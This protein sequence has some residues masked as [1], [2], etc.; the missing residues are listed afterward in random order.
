[1]SEENLTDVVREKIISKLIHA[2]YRPGH[3]FKLREMT[4]SDEFEGISQ[5]PIREALLQLVA[6][7]ILVGQR[8]FSIRVP[9]PTV[10]SL[11]EVR[12]IRIRLEIMAAAAG[13]GHWNKA[14][15][16]RL[17]AIHA[18]LMKAKQAEDTD[19]ILR[20]NVQFHF[21]LYEPSNMPYLMSMLRQLWAITGPS[22]RYLYETPNPVV[23]QG[24]HSHEDIIEALSARNL[25]Q[26]EEAIRAD[27][28]IHGQK[29]LDMLHRNLSLE[30]LAVQPFTKI[31]GTRKRAH[32]G[33]LIVQQS[34][35]AKPP[36]E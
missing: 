16:A 11:T 17:S 21:A 10:Q 19:D 14:R 25:P 3:A 9:T 24:R 35:E 34:Q 28:V 23:L 26:L 7:S 2:E 12:S 18:R 29:I 22:I 32:I 4:Q 13:I 27:G 5:T 36:G 1:M 6:Q 30:A 33:K 31:E 15:L 20:L 8:G